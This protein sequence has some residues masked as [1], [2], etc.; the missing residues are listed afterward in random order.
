[1]LVLSLSDESG[2][3]PAF[4]AADFFPPALGTTYGDSSRGPATL[5]R[6]FGSV[7]VL[8]FEPFG[9]LPGCI[10]PVKILCPCLSSTPH[11]VAS[12]GHSL[13]QRYAIVDQGRL[14]KNP[15]LQR[16]DNVRT[17]NS[18]SIDVLSSYTFTAAWPVFAPGLCTEYP[19]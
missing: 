18:Y 12:G 1:M 13:T 2:R 11:F 9:I 4:I 8:P 17:R 16:R 10:F 19:S 5:G 15:D 6:L 14:C 3:R 7:P